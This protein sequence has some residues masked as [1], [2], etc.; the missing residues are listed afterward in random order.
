MAST[1]NSG[2]PIP[3]H[4]EAK[5]PGK[6]GRGPTSIATSKGKAA[7]LPGNPAGGTGA[8]QGKVRGGRG[9]R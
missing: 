8:G 1:G 4:D 5:R 9:G 3:P 7:T 6:P 2:N